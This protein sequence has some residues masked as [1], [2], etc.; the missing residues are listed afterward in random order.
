VSAGAGDSGVPISVTVGGLRPHVRYHFRAVAT[1]ASGSARSVDRSFVTLREPSAI[2]IALTPSR[3]LWG[4]AITVIGRVIGTGIS[5]TPVAL[6][7]QAFPFQSA[8]GQVGPTRTVPSDGSFRFDI[9]FLYATTHFRVVTRSKVLV[10]STIHTASSVLKV[11]ATA[12]SRG[13]RRARISGAIWPLVPSG[14]VSLQKRSPRGHWAV[15]RRAAAKRLDVNR[16]RYS[17]TV[18]RGK[19]T[20]R[21]RVVVLAR[22]GGAHVPGRSREV[23]VRALRHAG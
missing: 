8:F 1:N 22:D 21:Y 5:G 2:S 9:P 3:V 14:R 18:K 17:F 20:G 19:K 16:S 7:S 10:A 23:R 13:A 6:E 4:G 15:V 11:G 12:R